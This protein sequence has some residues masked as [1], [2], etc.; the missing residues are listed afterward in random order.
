MS[1][2][3]R[4]WLAGTE[5]RDLMMGLKFPEMKGRGAGLPG[6]HRPPDPVRKEEQT[7]GEASAI[8][9]LDRMSC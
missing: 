1:T 5:L 7:L 3:S 6:P 2:A 9:F 4:A 8:C